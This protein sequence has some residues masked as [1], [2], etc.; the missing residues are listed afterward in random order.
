MSCLF[1]GEKKKNL[2][3]Y[4]FFIKV[5]SLLITQSFLAGI[6]CEPMMHSEYTY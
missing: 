2:L 5:I 4:V 1:H 3:K 6:F